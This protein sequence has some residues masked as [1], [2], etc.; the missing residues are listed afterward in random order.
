V[1][2]LHGSLAY[3]KVG[4]NSFV[5]YIRSVAMNRSGETVDVTTLALTDHAYLAGLKDATISFEG[6]FDP[7]LDGYMDAALA[8]ISTFEVGPQG[9][10]SGKV[11]WSG[12]A[13]LTRYN[14]T[15]STNDAGKFTGEMQVTGGVTVGTYA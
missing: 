1:A 5:A 6:F 2:K 11:K 8:A 10:T 13:I 12:S 14:P 15:F 7:T 3:F 9:S 4:S